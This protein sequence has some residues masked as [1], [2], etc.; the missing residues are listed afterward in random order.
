MRW[1]SK[2]H[3]RTTFCPRCRDADSLSLSLV[4]LL[5]NFSRYSPKEGYRMFN[6]WMGDPSKIVQ[7]E[8]VQRIT[9][10]QRLLEVGRRASVLAV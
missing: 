5:G 3:T 1:S 8:V 4:Y 9:R 6:T 7:L 10:E 2:F